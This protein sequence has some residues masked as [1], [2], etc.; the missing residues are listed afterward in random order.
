M[1]FLLIG[2]MGA[3]IGVAQSLGKKDQNSA[4]DFLRNALLIN[5]LLGA[6]CAGAF[7]F[8]AKPLVSFFPLGE[9]VV[10]DDAAAYL[11]IVA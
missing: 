3:E 6:L 5:L 8:A 7:I 1:G 11:C 10:L 9:T 2:R 4:I